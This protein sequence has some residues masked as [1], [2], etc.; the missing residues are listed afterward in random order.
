MTVSCYINFSGN[1]KEAMDFY[2]T[3]F[4][5]KPEIMTYGDM[6]ERSDLKVDERVKN[7]VMHGQLNLSGNRLMFSDVLPDMEL[8]EGNNIS[9]SLSGEEEEVLKKWYKG[10]ADGGEIVMPLEKTFWSELYGLVIDKF[11]IHWHINKSK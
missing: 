7:M 11:G 3:V 6:P 10:L 8:V 9:I 5:I 2:G 4:Q 1:C